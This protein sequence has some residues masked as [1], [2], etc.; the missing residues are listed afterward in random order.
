MPVNEYF[1]TST[2][3]SEQDFFEDLVIE[4]IQ[5]NGQDVLYIPREI[6]EIDPVLQEPK[7]TVF[8]R[9]FIIEVYT[10]DA[11][12]YSGE[13]NIMS[14][15]GFRINQTTEMIMSK[16]RFAE[17]GTDRLRPMEGDLIYIGDP[18]NPDFSLTNTLFEINQVW[19]NQPD[20]QFGKHFTYKL[21]LEAWVGSREKF[22]TGKIALDNMDTI[23]ETLEAA[24]R[25]NENIITA[26][27]DIIV[28]SFDRNNPF[29]D[30]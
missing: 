26:K 2:E 30:F 29:G 9:N 28:D 20:W 23:S 27:Q 14:K 12:Q 4:M 1:N 6:F 25:I 18:Y 3:T 16:K 15:F 19:F 13:Q 17:L 7:K 8:K 22:Q 24:S 11:Y 21:V 10:P 5:M